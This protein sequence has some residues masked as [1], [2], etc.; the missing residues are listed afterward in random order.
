MKKVLLSILF[1]SV[2]AFANAQKSEVAEAKRLWN[3]FQLQ[4]M[5]DPDAPK[6]KV[7][8]A[9][10]QTGP[11]GESLEDAKADQKTGGHG[12]IG[13]APSA[14]K[15]VESNKPAPKLSF[16]DRQ[17]ASL[18]EGL[19]HADKAV[20]HEKTKDSAEPWIYKALYSSQIA[21]VDTLNLQNSLAMQKEAEAALA[22]AVSLDTKNDE[23]DNITTVKANIR[24]TVTQRGVRAYNA[25][26]FSSAYDAFSQA[27]IINPADTSM[28]MN[29]GLVAKL[30]GKYP[31]AI[32]N[33]KKMIS[34][35]VP[36][37]KNYFI[38]IVNIQMSTLKDTTAA[39]ASIKE[40]LVKYPN[41][42]DFIGVQTDVFIQKGDIAKSQE[43]LKILIEKDPKK[44]VYHHLMGDTYYKQAL[45]L[46]AVRSKIDQ[47]KV[48][49][50]D[51]VTAKMV[52]L[53]DQALPYYKKAVE[54][55]PK[56][57]SSLETLK[58]LYAFKNDTK[59]YE[60]V[61]KQLDAIPA[62]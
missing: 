3:I 37:S 28:Y 29:A 60:E 17:V 59:N 32:Q 52:A 2:A 14:K 40:A 61:K 24:N 58:Q 26:D 19:S 6:Q 30:A 43:S 21:Y 42:P 48:K 4:M 39:L 46:Q 47:K 7:Q 41:D 51:A 45:A 23:K 8:R 1:V 27:L 31:E 25:K 57:V 34:F 22:K 15:P 18:K 5:Q 13:I 10:V 16:I 9:K 33:F 12:K 62:N 35:N 50:F 38:E 44:A 49:E 55:N 53:I 36:D 11:V 54:V 20:V 56:F